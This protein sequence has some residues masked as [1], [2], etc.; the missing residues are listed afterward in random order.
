LHLL[1]PSDTYVYEYGSPDSRQIAATYAKGNGNNNWWIAHLARVD[2]A[3]GAM[4]DLLAPP[5]R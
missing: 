5:I 3:T 2:V 1:T 4:R